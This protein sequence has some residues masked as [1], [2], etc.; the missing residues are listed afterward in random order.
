[1]AV[2]LNPPGFQYT[3]N[4]GD[5]LAGGK[6][7]FY[8]S[9][10]TTPKDTYTDQGAGTANANPVILDSAG[11]GAIW[12]D[13]SYKIVVKTSA[14]V[15]LDTKDVVTSFSTASG[16]TV[17][18][19][20]FI[21]QDDADNTKKLQ[22][23][24]SGITTGTTTTITVP[25]GNDTMVTLTGTQTLTNKTL[26]SP[27]ITTPIY[28]A[29]A[30]VASATTTDLGSGASNYI[31][32][33]GTT[34]ITGLGSTATTT[35]PI[36]FVK[37][38]D[39]L[40]LTHNATSLILPGGANITT[41]AGDVLIA[42]YEGSGNWR[43]VDYS[44][45]TG[46]PVAG[47]GKLTLLSSVTASSSAGIAFESLITS[48]YDEYLFEFIDLANASSGDRTEFYVS[49]DNGSSYTATISWQRALITTG[50]TTAPTYLG[51]TSPAQLGVG[52]TTVKKS[53]Y[54][55]LIV[56]AVGNGLV[57]SQLI[58]DIKFQVTSAYTAAA[59]NAVKFNLQSGTIV[60]GKIN[61]YG[62]KNT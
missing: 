45:A 44:K 15:T 36:Y 2:L 3:D 6:I 43:I 40:T 29:E 60:S 48:S 41:A 58:E 5:P 12:I 4:N 21:I 20:T 22:F 62:V 33:T 28:T 25:N 38:A 31:N 32:V 57:T 26:T 37:F 50:G 23:Q 10:T 13:G 8:E 35:N 51:G 30:T 61:M 56:A 49:T 42:K 14:D 19:S 27:T 54:V 46:A 52:S 34:T 59:V 18:D 16:T 1:M 17:T 7:Y 53:G 24:A 11:R 39:A 9:G 47:G 55:R